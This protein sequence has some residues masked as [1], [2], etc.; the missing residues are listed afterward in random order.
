VTIAGDGFG[1][2]ERVTC[3]GAG[4]GATG[5]GGCCDCVCCTGAGGLS[6]ETATV[7]PPDGPGTEEKLESSEAQPAT[8]SAAKNV[9][10]TNNFML[11]T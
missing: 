5:L 7:A 3:G 6:W 11:I 4:A 8:K 10:G 1:A 9:N 2:V